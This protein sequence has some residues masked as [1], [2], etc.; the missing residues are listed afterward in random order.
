MCASYILLLWWH[1]DLTILKFYKFD[2][3]YKH[4]GPFIQLS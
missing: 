4:A 1:L 2:S 3:F